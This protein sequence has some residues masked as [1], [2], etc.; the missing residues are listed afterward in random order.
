MATLDLK[1]I[2]KKKPLNQE[3]DIFLGFYIYYKFC[4]Y[5][6][7]DYLICIY[8]V[9]AR[10]VGQILCE[11]FVSILYPNSLLVRCWNS[12]LWS[13]QVSAE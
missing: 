7:T 6:V 13:A 9:P 8:R 10:K 12:Y 4:L 1:Q 11:V 2:Q 3:N 5:A